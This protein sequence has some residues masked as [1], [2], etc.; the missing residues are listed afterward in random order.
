M[1]DPRG[2][3]MAFAGL[4]SPHRVAVP[5]AEHR[6]YNSMLIYLDTREAHSLVNQCW[7]WR[8]NHGVTDQQD[9]NT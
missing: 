6:V 7:L 9:I 5:C 8:T 1:L 4:P 2:D 3:V